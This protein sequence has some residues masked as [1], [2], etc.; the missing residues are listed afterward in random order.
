[1]IRL[2]GGENTYLSFEKLLEIKKL[3]LSDDP[4]IQVTT[5]NADE[6][7]SAND[8]LSQGDMIGF[9]SQKSLII[10]KRLMSNKSKLLREDFLEKIKNSNY[11][12]V[13]WEDSNLDKRTTL[14]KYFLKNGE[15]F[16]LKFLNE[17]QLLPWITQK[18]SSSNININY[19]L[20][21]KLITRVGFDQNILNSEINKIISYEK[22]QMSTSV[23]ESTI[24]LLVPLSR[25]ES[26]WD[27][28]DS[29]SNGSINKAVILLETLLKE[30]K[31]YPLVM[32]LIV[33]QIRI[34]YTIKNL[35]NLNTTDISKISGIHSFVVNKSYSIAKRIEMNSLR[36]AYE[37]LLNLDY[38]V[39]TGNID[40]KLG[41]DLFILTFK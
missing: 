33:R 28:I 7:K 4:L 20:A 19:N 21:E 26:I 11:E 30:P 39:K 17:K 8:L 10:L 31:D 3:Y 34:L 32:S 41:L 40:P 36:L 6:A 13:L 1:M 37:R 16:D 2:I 24:S 23:Q 27:L 25:E 9:F 29:I 14:Y 18:F 5:I 15:V 38:K 22:S 35:I 12:I